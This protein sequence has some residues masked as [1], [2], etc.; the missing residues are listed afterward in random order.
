MQMVFLLGVQIVVRTLCKDA[1]QYVA[2]VLHVDEN[3]S[4]SGTTGQ[5]SG[6]R[7]PPWKDC[8]FVLT[9]D[10]RC[11]P[12]RL[13][14]L[15]RHVGRFFSDAYLSMSCRCLILL[16]LV[17]PFPVKSFFTMRQH[18]FEL[19]AH[20]YPASPEGWIPSHSGQ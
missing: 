14:N 10:T 2:P 8:H 16:K 19:N 4:C 13:A 6:H 17:L 20:A 15:L 3:R 18:L 9:A 7:R 12:K 11:R 5:S 1:L